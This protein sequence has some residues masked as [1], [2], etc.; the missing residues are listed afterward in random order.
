M[1]PVAGCAVLLAACG[2]IPSASAPEV[3][4]RVSEDDSQPRVRGD[5]PGPV[6]GDTPQ[7]I[8]GGF[9]DAM[10]IYEEYAL[11]DG[12]AAEFMTADAAENW[13]PLSEILV[14]DGEP[15]ISVDGDTATLTV[16][17]DAKYDRVDG[18]VRRPSSA[19]P[20]ILELPLARVG[21]EWRLA[22][23]PEGLLIEAEQ[24]GAEFESYNLY[25]FNTSF[26]GTTLV[27][28]PV[29]LPVGAENKGTLL[30]QELLDG[31]SEWLAP[32]VETAFPDGATIEPESVPVSAGVARVT[33]SRPAVS[34]P[35]G[36]LTSTETRSRM[37]EQLARTLGELR[38]VQQLE[39]TSGGTH[40]TGSDENPYVDVADRS[41]TGLRDRLYA[42]TESGVG[43]V[44]DGPS[45]VVTPVAGP[46]GSRTGLLEVAVDRTH[47]AAAAVTTNNELIRA[48][49]DPDSEVTTLFGDAVYDS[50]EWDG[51]G[52]LWAI[53]RPQEEGDAELEAPEVEPGEAAEVDE[54]TKGDSGNRLLVIDPQTSRSVDVTPQT[55]GGANIEQFAIAPDGARIAF[56]I[57]GTAYLAII[58]RD[59]DNPL[60]PSTIEVGGLRP[61]HIDQSSEPLGGVA[62]YA[63]DE[64]GLIT[65]PEPPASEEIS[66]D[67]GQAPQPEPREPKVRLTGLD[68]LVAQEERTITDGVSIAAPTV[69]NRL[70]VGTGS[71]EMWVRSKTGR[72][73]PLDGLTAPTYAG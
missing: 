49:L 65:A 15:E 56:V 28:D 71:G 48:D 23:A 52:L 50:L 21:S 61:L 16:A 27:P 47:R 38:D 33:L 3:A 51:S 58:E 32:A 30:V 20:E 2:G 66:L 19:D 12:S 36:A 55:P 18:F 11:P 29:Y 57:D 35:D 9:L 45:P 17:V 43:W 41:S 64:L 34:N 39:V 25:F 14:Y 31:P 69:D 6:E 73:M 37:V 44:A 5:R 68:D 40:L 62:W 22:A 4:E 46:L 54:E 63:P 13:K 1:V 8:V 60:E 72:W 70:A 53:E 10:D 24:F 26:D 42:V 59:P 7:Q 67:P